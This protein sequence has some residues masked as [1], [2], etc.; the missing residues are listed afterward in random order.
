MRK[1]RAI[2]THQYS[3]WSNTGKYQD[4]MFWKTACTLNINTKY[5]A[6]SLIIKNHLQLHTNYSMIKNLLST[7]EKYFWPILGLI[8]Q[9]HYLRVVKIED[10]CWLQRRNYSI[11]NQAIKSD[12][13][14]RTHEFIHSLFWRILSLERYRKR[15][16]WFFCLCFP[17]ARNL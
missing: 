17:R 6:H 1:F 10:G 7:Q 14:E 3:N 8:Y 15:K 9:L 5:A 13:T 4:F 12:C 16:K 2:C 11:K